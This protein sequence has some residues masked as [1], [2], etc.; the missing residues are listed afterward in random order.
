VKLGVVG[1]PH[2]LRG[3]LHV[4][5]DPSIPATLQPTVRLRLV[6]ATDSRQFVVEQV[7]DAPRGLVLA[8]DGV[9]DRSEAER[10]V[11]ADVFISRESLSRNADSYFDFELVGLEAVNG[12]GTVL[13][14]VSEVLATGANDVLVIASTGGGE[15]LIPAITRA[16]LGVDLEAGRLV[17][18]ER[19]AVRNDETDGS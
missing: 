12:E 16:L 13:G 14:R 5:S 1:R 18:D 10:W 9:R 7:R 2:G 19:T 17:V 8:L 15:I 3:E 11:G 6:T 4:A